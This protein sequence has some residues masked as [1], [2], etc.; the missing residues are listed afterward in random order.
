MPKEYKK[1]ELVK[2]AKRDNNKKR[3]YLLVDPLQGKHIPVSPAKA[4]SLFRTLADK[5]LEN[6]PEEK[7]LVIGFAETATAIGAAVTPEN[8]WYIQTTREEAADSEYLF[9]SEAHSHASEQKLIKNNL[10]EMIE[11]TDR[12]LFAEDE[13][14]TGNTI[15]NIKEILEKEYPEKKLK[16]GVISILNG[17][18]DENSRRFDREEIKCLYLIKLSEENYDEKLEKYTYENSLKHRSSFEKESFHIKKLSLAGYINSRK[19]I[20][21]D[22]YRKICLKL[23]DDIM[24]KLKK[25]EFEDKTLLVLGA[26]EFM[27]PAMVTGERIE[28][29]W[30]CSEVKFH[31][32][33]RSPIL[34]SSEEDYPLHSRYELKSLYD[35][36]RTVYIYDLKKYDKVI[37]IHDS[38]ESE[39]KGFDTLISALRKNKCED[40]TIFQ[41]SDLD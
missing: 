5:I 40:I 32:L 6:Y 28:R 27:Y 30:K 1:E 16:F 33:T 3:S 34:P 8:S 4:L 25:E 9:F 15:W 35:E 12:I 31:A 29:E 37:I 36:K 13:I 19:G 20:A 18:N 24:G 14:T 11:K 26:E 21:G 7:L 17:M 2:I 10:K 41:W 38:T 22:E 23:A 39:G